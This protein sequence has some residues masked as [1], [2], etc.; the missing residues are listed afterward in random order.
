MNE[1]RDKERQKEK[2]KEMGK[3]YNAEKEISDIKEVL[4]TR[5][6]TCTRRG[7]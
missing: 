6:M 3:E 5:Y 7:L 4:L 2:E 1:K